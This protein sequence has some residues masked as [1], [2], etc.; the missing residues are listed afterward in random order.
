MTQQTKIGK[1]KHFSKK[2]KKNVPHPSGEINLPELAEQNHSFVLAKDLGE[3]AENQETR[4]QM[5]TKNTGGQTSGCSQELFTSLRRSIP[6]DFYAL[7]ELSLS[8]KKIDLLIV[9]IDFI[10]FVFFFF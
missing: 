4:T 9:A 2:K 5:R 7:Y 1:T 8:S 3:G 6:E 10:D